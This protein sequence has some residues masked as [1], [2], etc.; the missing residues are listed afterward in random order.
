MTEEKERG[1]K[2]SDGHKLSYLPSE[3]YVAEL[4]AEL[5]ELREFKKRVMVLNPV[6]WIEHHKAGQNL[7]WE[8]VNH[9]YSKATPL[10]DL[11][12]IKG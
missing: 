8:E 4:E 5:T 11:K 9:N 1:M 6:A 2:F 12:G 7:N 10:Y 3:R